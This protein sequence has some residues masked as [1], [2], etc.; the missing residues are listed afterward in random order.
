MRDQMIVFL[1]TSLI[2]LLLTNV[3]S[4]LV[5]FYAM[6]TANLLTRPAEAKHPIERR[7]QAILT[8]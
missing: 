4:V 1:Q 3:V 5:A 6:K 7:L 8:R 2:F